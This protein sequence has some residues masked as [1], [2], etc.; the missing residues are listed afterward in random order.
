VGVPKQRSLYKSLKNAAK[1]DAASPSTT[2]F[3]VDLIKH[4]LGELE[5]YEHQSLIAVNVPGKDYFA[6]LDPTKGKISRPVSVSLFDLDLCADRLD[7]FSS[8]AYRAL[9]RASL[10]KLLYTM[11]MSFCC[12][13]DMRTSGDKKTPATFFECFVANIFS[14]ELGV[15]PTTK[16]EVLNLDMQATLP[17]DYLFN[18]GPGKAKIHLPI[19]ISTRERVVQVWAH[20]RVLDG[21]YGVGRFRG[22]LVVITETNLVKGG[23][24]T[25]VCL[26]DQWKVYQMFISQLKR[27]YYLDLPMKYANLAKTYPFLQVKSFAEFFREKDKLISATVE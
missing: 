21:V 16:A 23:K 8:G 18:L 27:I 4:S 22:V 20:Q 11:A 5:K 14:R 15:L 9:P 10:E 17:T 7:D 2:Q 24:V 6:F 3:L 1:L 25:E 12:A 26:P 13:N 19:K